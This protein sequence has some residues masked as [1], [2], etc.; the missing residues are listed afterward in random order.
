[1]VGATSVIFYNYMWI[2]EKGLNSGSTALQIFSYFTVQSNLIVLLYTLYSMITSKVRNTK[3][4]MAL[5]IYITFTSSV[6]A[7]FLTRI[8]LYDTFDI[9]SITVDHFITPLCFIIDFFIVERMH[10][11]EWRLE[12]KDLLLSLLYPFL[13][14][15]YILIYGSITGHYIYPFLDVSKIGFTGYM[16]VFA[17]LLI[18]YWGMTKFYTYIMNRLSLKPN[19]V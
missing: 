19:L 11:S 16:F 9:F 14:I 6:Y 8:F 2:F 12:L 3:I 5:M 13:Y 18:I 17:A 15:D 4:K 1:M 10:H 7:F